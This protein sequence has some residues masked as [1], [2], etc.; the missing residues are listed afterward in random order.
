[1]VWGGKK[2]GYRDFPSSLRA[3]P[4]GR[5]QIRATNCVLEL[6]EVVRSRAD[7]PLCVFFPSFC[8]PPSPA[9]PACHSP[10]ARPAGAGQGDIRR[11]VPTCIP[12]GWGW[13][14]P[15]ARRAYGTSKTAQPLHY[16]PH[17]SSDCSH[18]E[19]QITIPLFGWSLV[20]GL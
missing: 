19:P 3:L 10:A 16:L 14:P 8:P 6:R 18:T 20:M 11:H 2:G 4:F 12:E 15:C 1:M 13:V 17:P 7:S 9:A 5:G